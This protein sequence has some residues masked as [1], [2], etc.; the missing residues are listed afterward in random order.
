MPKLKKTYFLTRTIVLI[1]LALT[2]F[3]ASCSDSGGSSDISQSTDI[4]ESLDSSTAETVTDIQKKS[5]RE[6]S[7]DAIARL[8]EIDFGGSKAVFAVKNGSG[9]LPDDAESVINR[10]KYARVNLLEEKFNFSA[11]R[12]SLSDN[13]L[14]N[15]ARAAENSGLY[16]ADLLCISP[17]QLWRYALSGYAKKPQTLPF[18]TADAPYFDALSTAQTASSKQPAGV[19]GALNA[20]PSSLSA[21]LFNKNL[22]ATL[23]EAS[24][25]DYVKNGSWTLEKFNELSKLAAADNGLNGTVSADTADVFAEKLFFASHGNYLSKS[26]GRAEYSPFDDTAQ[27][28]ADAVSALL[29]S[30]KQSFAISER[31]ADELFK[32]EKALFVFTELSAVDDLAELGFDWG[33][34]PSPTLDGSE[35]FSLPGNGATVSIVLS[36]TPDLT[37]SGVLLESA[38][39]AMYGY[40]DELYLEHAMNYILRDND[41]VNMLDKIISSVR[42]D[43]AYMY[44]GGV[45]GLANATYRAAS[46]AVNTN[47]GLEYYNRISEGIG[48]RIDAL[49]K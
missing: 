35:P 32:S 40:V 5:K 34:L 14:F 15:Q 48:D 24:L 37:R 3:F 10:E 29:Y 42:Y 21:I 25:Y 18:Y 13:E 23:G 27:Q 8:D 20:D 30:S 41:S 43:F 1:I 46:G 38:N 17:G 9:A 36:E 45:R 7:D 22:A 2:L 44:S 11:V 6:I 28:L 33:I 39:A 4:S 31:R 19:V 49:S 12:L 47:H 26:D 16:F